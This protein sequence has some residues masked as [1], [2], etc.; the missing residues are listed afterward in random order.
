[1]NKPKLNKDGFSL[2]ELMIA[3]TILA[4]G[5]LAVAQM[6]VIAIRGN[7][8]SGRLA[9]ATNFLQEKLEEFRQPSAF[10]IT[11]TATGFANQATVNDLTNNKT[12]NDA[13]LDCA[14]NTEPG[15]AGYEPDWTETLPPPTTPN[16]RG[17]TYTRIVN[18]RN[19][20][21]D[22]DAPPCNNEEAL[23][24]EVNVIITWTEGGI[25]HKISSRTLV[26][27]KDREFF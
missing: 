3:M 19:I 15:C 27:G 6:Q 20:C 2:V 4:Y 12:T 5:L 17:N 23:A 14:S 21:E 11:R 26:T 7:T 10:F 9:E 16:P 8:D 24:K 25:A 22:S 18:V 13:Q 1:M